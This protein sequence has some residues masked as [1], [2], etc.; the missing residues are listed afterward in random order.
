ML[1][2]VCMSTIAQENLFNLP[3]LTSPKSDITCIFVPKFINRT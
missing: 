3:Q 1:I 2:A